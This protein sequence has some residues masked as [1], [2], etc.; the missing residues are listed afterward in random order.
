MVLGV[1]LAPRLN[2]R[3]PLILTA[4]GTAAYALPLAAFGLSAPMPVVATA[5]LIAMSGLGILIP[6]WATEV[7]RRIPE[8]SLG[9]VDSIDALISFAA[10]SLGLAVAAPLATLIGTAWPLLVA[11]ALVAVVNLAVLA[12]PDIRRPW[13]PAPKPAVV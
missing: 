9:R 6:L 1:F 3:R 10:R 12:L 2:V 13:T 4:A 8:H 5:Y 11:A 7:Q